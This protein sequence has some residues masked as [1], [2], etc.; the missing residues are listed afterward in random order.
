MAATSGGLDQPIA[1]SM[2]FTRRNLLASA[3]LVL[4]GC[5]THDARQPA[6]NLRLVIN[7]NYSAMYAAI[8]DEPFRCRRVDLTEIDPRYLRREVA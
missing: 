7:S 1:P 5:V 2:S 8:D 4:A 3:P 6:T